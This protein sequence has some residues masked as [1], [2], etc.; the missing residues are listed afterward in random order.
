MADPALPPAAPARH[1]HASCITAT[2]RSRLERTA[3]SPGQR[4]RR[5]HS[6]SLRLDEGPRRRAD[7]R[8]RARSGCW[9]VGERGLAVPSSGLGT[10]SAPTRQRCHKDRHLC[11]APA[12]PLRGRH[13]GR[14]GWTPPGHTP[15]K[16]TSRPAIVQHPGSDQPWRDRTAVVTDGCW[17]PDGGQQRSRAVAGLPPALR[18]ERAGGPPVISDGVRASE[19]ASGRRRA[20]EVRLSSGRGSHRAA[21]WPSLPRTGSATCTHLLPYTARERML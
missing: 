15:T 8:A 3:Q 19:S 16:A 2:R 21:G 1:R 6:A 20:E 10:R 12:S 18:A 4:F 13:G 7:R 5:P 9:R 11:E 17:P 14:G